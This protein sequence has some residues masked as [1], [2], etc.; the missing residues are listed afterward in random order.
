MLSK[1][2]VWHEWRGENREKEFLDTESGFYHP[3]DVP[4]WVACGGPKGIKVAAR[5]AD[6]TICCLGPNADMIKLVKSRSTRLSPRPAAPQ[7]RQLSF[8]GAALSR[9]RAGPMCRAGALSRTRWARGPE[10]GPPGRP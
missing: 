7:A 6:A 10:C 5:Y 4:I 3:S 2:R 9:R 8:S 1:E